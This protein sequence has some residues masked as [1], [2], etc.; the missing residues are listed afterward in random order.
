MENARV[1]ILLHG[2]VQGV[3]FRYFVV[4]TARPMGITGYVRNRRDGSVEVVAEGP[5]DRL[6]EFS[7]QVGEGPR[8]G[9][10]S[11]LE[12]EWGEHT[13]EFGSFDV[14]F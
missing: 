11:N 5:R 6:E 3:G 14:R 7:R 10:V 13:G 4:T 8:H 2:I 9:N 1:R 12:V